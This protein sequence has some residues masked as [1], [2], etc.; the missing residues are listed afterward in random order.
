MQKRFCAG[1]EAEESR[2]WLRHSQNEG[3]ETLILGG[4][5]VPYELG[6]EGHSDADVLVHAI[7]DA[8]LGAAGEGDIGRHFP[9]RR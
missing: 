4:I 2:H 6:L 7:C 5:Q 8:L 3:R 9:S 1:G